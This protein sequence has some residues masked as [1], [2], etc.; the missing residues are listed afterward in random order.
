MQIQKKVI[1]CTSQGDRTIRLCDID[2]GKLVAPLIEVEEGVLCVA[3]SPDAD[4]PRVAAGWGD[5]KL[6]KLQVWDAKDGRLLLDLPGHSGYVTCVAYSPHGENIISGS[7]DGTVRIWE[8]NNGRLTHCL[9][10]GSGVN[11]IAMSHDGEKIASGAFNGTL[12][13]W[14]TKTG[15]C[16]PG[17]MRSHAGRITLL[18]FTPDNQQIISGSDDRTIRIWEVES[19]EESETSEQSRHHY[20]VTFSPDRQKVAF[21]SGRTLQVWDIETQQLAQAQFIGHEGNIQSLAFSHDERMIASGA[22]DHVIYIWNISSGNKIIGP[23][24]G[25]E[26]V[27][28]SNVVFSPEDTKFVSVSLFCAMQTWDISTGELLSTVPLGY[29]WSEGPV[30][31]SPVGSHVVSGSTSR[32]VELWD[33]LKDEIVWTSSQCHTQKVTSLAFSSAGDRVVSGSEDHT[34]NIWDAETGILLNGPFHG[35]T[36]P[37]L[38]LAFSPDG[39]KIVSGAEDRSIILWD[40]G[41]TVPLT[42]PMQGHAD[43]L[44]FVDFAQDRGSQLIIS[45][46]YDKSIR[47]WDPSDEAAR[48]CFSPDAAHALDVTTLLSA[49]EGL[50]FDSV[51]LS[52]N[53][54]W[55]VG[56]QNEYIFWVP[57]SY[58]GSL[59]MPRYVKVAGIQSVVLDLSRLPHGYSW[60]KCWKSETDKGVY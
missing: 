54:G 47:V 37:V 41:K 56:P 10:H 16:I 9:D 19:A 20:C 45:G 44:A 38:T 32:F 33:Y 34:I 24:K 55:I 48:I 13:I 46:S 51:T 7:L 1:A 43:R 42:Q 35:H 18:V 28:I 4:A 8:A 29:S 6:Q 31:L 59:W 40:V 49:G 22:E 30:V 12:K 17:P 15:T 2:N 60:T 58:R 52:R 26:Y 3:L 5:S 50:R 21:T 14:E 27:G 39:E 57:P 23:L 36:S 53:I 11:A 25:K